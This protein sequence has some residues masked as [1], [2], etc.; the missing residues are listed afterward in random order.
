[1]DDDT[2]SKAQERLKRIAGQVIGIQRMVVA[3]RYCVDILHQV[4]A[5]R[6]A[7]METGR[8]VLAG[9]VE[10]CLSEAIRS[11]DERE[12]R[13]QVNELIDLFSRFCRLDDDPK[14]K[15]KRRAP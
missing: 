5:A 14:A 4:A 9:H 1:M 10:N 2:R 13:R 12:R 3:D 8:V 11:H 15:S 6:A 7:L